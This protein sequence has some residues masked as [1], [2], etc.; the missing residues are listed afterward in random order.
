[1]PKMATKCQNYSKKGI[2]ISSACKKYGIKGKPLIDMLSKRYKERV[3]R[4]VGLLIKRNI[5]CE[6]TKKI[7]TENVELIRIRANNQFVTSVYILPNANSYCH[8]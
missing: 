8:K 3:K 4:G 6:V 7:L 1:M 2:L 5:E